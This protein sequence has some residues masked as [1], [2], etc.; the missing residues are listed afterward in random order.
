MN[1][2]HTNAENIL[3]CRTN[4]YTSL[5]DSSE[6]DIKDIESVEQTQYDTD[7]SEIKDVLQEY[8]EVKS[9]I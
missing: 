6:S 2:N 7:A 1:S 4:V 3:S 8:I 5:E 9:E